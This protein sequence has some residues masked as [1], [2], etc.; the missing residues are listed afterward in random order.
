[1]KTRTTTRIGAIL[2]GVLS[3]VLLLIHSSFAQ[4]IPPLII[5]TNT[6]TLPTNAVKMQA[7]TPVP[8]PFPPVLPN[9]PAP[10]TNFQ[11]LDDNNFTWPPDTD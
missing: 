1:M 6:G 5:V 3:L 7:P 9:S 10:A 8:S 2:S 11:G 4:D